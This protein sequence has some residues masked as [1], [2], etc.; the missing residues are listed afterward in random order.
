MGVIVSLPEDMPLAEPGEET[1]CQV[2]LFNAG[3]V[4]DHFTLDILG[5]AKEWVTVEPCE[6]NV[7][8]GQSTQAELVFRPPRSAEVVAG[9]TDFALRVLSHEDVEGSAIEEARVTVGAYHEFNLSLVPRRKRARFSAR[10]RAVCDNLGN[11]PVTL[12]FFASDADAKLKFRFKHPVVEVER[13]S[14]VILPLKVRPK[15]RPLRGADQ[16]IPFQVLAVDTDDTEVTADGSLVQAPV[17]PPTAF[18][19][20]ALVAAGVVALIALWFLVLQPTVA[21]EAREQAAEQN[22][23]V[24]ENASEAKK[25]AESAQRSAAAGAGGG[26]GAGR[27]PAL[28]NASPS[29]DEDSKESGTGDSD[30]DLAPGGA[31]D[32]GDGPFRAIDFRIQASAKQRDSDAFDT[33]A[34]YTVPDG[35]TV[36]VSDIIFE[37][38]AGDLGVVRLLRED[39]SLLQ[40]SLDSFRNIDYHFVEPLEFGEGQRIVLSVRCDGPGGSLSESSTGGTC[41]PAAYISGRAVLDP[42]D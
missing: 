10:Y 4:V 17:L 12:Q 14:G 22:E 31:D 1:R 16:A 32:R 7:Y 41:T 28:E 19:I 20:A 8:P 13:G 25:D 26:G 33:Q 24:A 5:D 23:E 40:L 38:S 37:N 39:Q 3:T 42:S 18:K 2:Q 15:Q 27:Y 11:A 35:M 9:E 29:D 21:S 36:Y 34:Y 30:Q 6:V